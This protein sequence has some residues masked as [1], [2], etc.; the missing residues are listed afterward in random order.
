MFERSAEQANFFE[1]GK[2]RLVMP[3][4]ALREKPPETPEDKNKNGGG[5]GGGDDGLSELGLDPLLVALL[6]KIPTSGEWPA[7]QRLRWFRTFA[8][9]VSQIYDGDDKEPVEM[10]IE[11]DGLHSKYV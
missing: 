3:A 11:L 7:Q 6:K 5:T 10:K 1:H 8:M 9:N 2:N 4:V